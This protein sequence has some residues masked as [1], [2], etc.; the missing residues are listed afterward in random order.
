MPIIDI[1]VHIQPWEQLKPGVREKM[2]AGRKDMAAIEEFIHSPNT[3]LEFLDANGVEAAGLI[4]YPSP[5][6][7]GFT[8]ATNDFVANYCKENPRRLIAFGGVHP[9][10]CD[11]VNTEVTRL[12]KLGIRCLKVHPPHQAIAAN[13]YRYGHAAQQ[14]LYRRAE[15]ENM[16]M[17]FHGGTSI[18]PG[19][20]NVYADT[21]PID[22]VAVDFPQLK[23]IIAHAG[24]PLHVDTTFFL[25]RRHENVHI[26]ISGIPPKKLLEYLPRLPEI[27]GKTLWGT[28]WPSP[29]V[30]DMRKNIEDFLELPLE[31]ETKDAI[32]HDNAAR[33]LR[34]C[35]AIS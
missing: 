11:D 28:D 17:M 35:G 30:V 26:D 25:L 22:D 8:A 31:Q 13:A 27:A 19:A 9:R 12:L 34:A 18:F 3:F 16:L 2:T 10:F 24:R 23:I 7:M 21:M 1:H 20:R 14:D 4:N 5:D 32:L 6:L 15:K 33:L 29:G